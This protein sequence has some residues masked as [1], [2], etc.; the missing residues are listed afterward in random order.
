M[1]KKANT[2][3]IGVFVIGAVVLAIAGILIFGSGK[4]FRETKEFVL[5]FQGSVQGLNKGAPVAFKGVRVGSVTN[6]KI[7]FDSRDLSLQIP[8]FI[9]IEPDRLTRAEGAVELSRVIEETKGQTVMAFLVEKGLRAQLDMQ[10]LVTGQLFVNLDF[11]P[12]RS[13]RYV[14]IETG[15]PEIPTI[16]SSLENL[17]KT[18]EQLPISELA[19]KANRVLKAI[20]RWLNSPELK[21]IVDSA[22]LTMK[23]VASITA[24]ADDET[25]PLLSR[26]DKTL[27]EMQGLAHDIRVHVNPLAADMRELS[28][29]AKKL[30]GGIN[31][32]LG[33]ITSG[34]EKTLKAAEL[35]LTKAESTLGGV[36]ETLGKESPLRLELYNTLKELSTAAR[37]LRV[38][39][40]YLER[41]PEALLRGKG[42]YKGR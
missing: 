33:D 25:R 14:S 28:G 21:E 32:R 23:H 34:L 40:D 9:E 5:F 26:T 27:A 37:S 6:V 11:F 13:A 35:A 3:I 17:S 31:S 41:H 10:S 39:A 15:Y 42:E 4:F 7:I 29:E 16:P 12:E 24:K 19:S 20:E 36:E 8:V 38:F 30:V 1:S 22:N 18:V 2:T